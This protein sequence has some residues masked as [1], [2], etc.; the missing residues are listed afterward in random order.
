MCGGFFEQSIL[1]GKSPERSRLRRSGLKFKKVDHRGARCTPR[2]RLHDV[3]RLGSADVVGPHGTL[4]AAVTAAGSHGH[5]MAADVD[6][7]A[8]APA[9]G[10]VAAQGAFRPPGTGVVLVT[11]DRRPGAV[12]VHLCLGGGLDV[13]R[14]ALPTLGD[15]LRRR[16]T[17]RRQDRHREGAEDPHDHF[18]HHNLHRAKASGCKDHPCTLGQ[19]PDQAK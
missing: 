8:G 9:S 13:L 15:I 11:P 5:A 19:R 6:V 10:L 3:T 1:L 18:F 16:R 7:P 12:P 14:L 17:G 2:P 4:A